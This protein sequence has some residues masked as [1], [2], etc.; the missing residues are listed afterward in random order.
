LNSSKQPADSEAQESAPGSQERHVIFKVAT[1]FCALP[2][3]MEVRTRKLEQCVCAML[4]MG[5]AEDRARNAL[6]MAEDHSVNGALEWM[7]SHEREKVS[8]RRPQR[9][10]F[11]G[12][13]RGIGLHLKAY[14]LLKGRTSLCGAEGLNL[15]AHIRSE[16]AGH[17]LHA[18]LC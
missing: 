18:N 9:H 13:T 3:R 1:S 8:G 7:S 2:I 6:L 16:R 11:F 15:C 10:S 14:D 17:I 12:G 4:E 5:I